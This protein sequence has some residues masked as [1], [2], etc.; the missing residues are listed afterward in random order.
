MDPYGQRMS[1]GNIRNTRTGLALRP[2]DSGPNGKE[3]ALWPLPPGGIGTA[4]FHVYLADPCGEY[5]AVHHILT[6]PYICTHIPVSIHIHIITFRRLIRPLQWDHHRHIMSIQKYLNN[7]GGKGGNID[8]LRDR[9][10]HL[11]KE[12]KK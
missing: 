5:R 6:L 8:T 7:M 9:E 3:I 11:R 4:G 2:F 12:N 10:A 1:K